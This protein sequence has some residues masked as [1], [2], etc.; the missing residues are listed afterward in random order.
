MRNCEEKVFPVNMTFRE[1]PD[2][3]DIFTMEEFTEEV[4]GGGI[5]NYDGIGRLARVD[6]NGKIWEAD[7]EVD[8][9]LSWLVK[10]SPDFTH[11]CW[12]NK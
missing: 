12:Y 9:R 5:M 10:Q 1:A 11:V 3:A 8:C 4:V 6:E 2:Y 7:V